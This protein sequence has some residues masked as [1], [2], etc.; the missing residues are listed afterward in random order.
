[1]QPLGSTWKVERECYQHKAMAG[2]ERFACC[3]HPLGHEKSGGKC[4]IVSLLRFWRFFSSLWTLFVC[5][6]TCSWWNIKHVTMYLSYCKIKTRSRVHMELW[7]APKLCGSAV[8][9]RSVKAVF[10]LCMDASSH[11]LL[12][13]GKNPTTRKRWISDHHIAQVCAHELEKLIQYQWP[14]LKTTKTHC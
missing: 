11:W 14:F 6:S 9:N 12:S 8:V 3:L 5:F 4:L 13:R 1:M 7:L 2:W 10:E